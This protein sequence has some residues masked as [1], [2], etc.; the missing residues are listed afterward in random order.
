MSSTLLL[1]RI[2]PT[3]FHD[4]NS[5]DAH[6]STNDKILSNPTQHWTGKSQSRTGKSSQETRPTKT[7]LNGG[8]LRSLT[9]EGELLSMRVEE[10][11]RLKHFPAIT[12]DDIKQEEA[13]AKQELDDENDG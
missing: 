11:L 5:W 6:F 12:K 7:P 10:L 2:S 1:L 13:T 9:G 3:I 4:E 8:R